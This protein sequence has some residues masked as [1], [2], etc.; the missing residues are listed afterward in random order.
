MRYPINA[1]VIKFEA[2]AITVGT[3][4]LSSLEWSPFTKYR[5]TMAFDIIMRVKKKAF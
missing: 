2:V 3:K 5:H 1:E 4:V